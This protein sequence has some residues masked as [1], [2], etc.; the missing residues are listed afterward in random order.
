MAHA[1][2]PDLPAILVAR[3]QQVGMQPL[4]QTPVPVLNMSYHANSFSYW[5][6]QIIR[7]FVVG[8]QAVTEAE[9][10]AWLKEFEALE[11]QGAYFFR[12]MPV[13]TEAVKIA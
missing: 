7:L 2:Y 10:E 5:L 11:H 9:A 8:R 13:L 6:A 1:H 4:R 3:L 12:S